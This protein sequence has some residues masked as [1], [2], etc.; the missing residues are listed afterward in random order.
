M[1]YIDSVRRATHSLKNAK[2]RTLLTSLAIAVGAF[3]LTMSIAAGTGARQ[4]ADRLL[5]SNIDPQSLLIYK[6][7]KLMG[8]SGG[9]NTGLQEYNQDSM[10]YGGMNF[11][12]L[13]QNDIET[14][15]NLPG[16]ERVTPSY[17]IKTQYVQFPGSTKKYISEVMTY[18]S[19]VRAEVAAGTLPP[20][21]Q[22]IADNEVVLPQSYADSLKQK[23]AD[24]IGKT[25]TLRL[26][27]AASARPSDEQIQQIFMEGGM[28]A[29]ENKFTPEQ[30]DVSLIVRAVSSKSST[31]FSASNALFISDTQ[32][33]QLNDFITSGTDQF[34]KYL[35]A[36]VT[37]KKGTTPEAMKKKVEEKN[38]L[39]MTPKDLQGMIFTIVNL[40]QGI[41]AGFGVLALIA[42]IFGIINTQYISVL[43]RT[44]EIGLMKALGMRRRHVSRLFQ[45]EAAWIGLLGGII[46]SLLAWGVGT[47]LNPWISKKIGIGDNHLLIFELLPVLG[48]LALLMLV[49]MTAG[50]VPARKAAKLDP[51]EALRTE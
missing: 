29:L 44:R 14:V 18:D 32:A 15:R 48:L 2:G 41:V 47:A 33:K 43:E 42:S 39:A 11:T 46:G 34:E 13:T 9:P 25:V 36:T 17:L 22:Q 4:Y 7:K 40:L 38:I 45:L 31:S 19:T 49:A 16:V 10:A 50:W 6:D 27:K 21:K 3:T 26:A 30:R 5:T 51:I 1:K 23:P 8:M 20:L 37:I 24:L 12:S 35:N 28:A